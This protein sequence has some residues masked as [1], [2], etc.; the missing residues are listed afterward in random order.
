MQTNLGKHW[1][2]LPD[3]EV[4]GLLETDRD[5]GLD[6]SEVT[7][8]QQQFGPNVLTQKKGESPLLLFLAQL[9][10]P[11]VVNTSLH[12]FDEKPFNF[13][14]RLCQR[15]ITRHSHDQDGVRDRPRFRP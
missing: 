7:R 6:Y 2:Q 11:L 14:L 5:R 13:G 12:H 1:H 9:N 15:Q 10:Q 8:R 4:L 3:T